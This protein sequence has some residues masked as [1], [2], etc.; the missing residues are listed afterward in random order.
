MQTNVDSIHYKVIL[1][2]QQTQGQAEGLTVHKT[3]GKHTEIE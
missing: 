2:L 3:W 1:I